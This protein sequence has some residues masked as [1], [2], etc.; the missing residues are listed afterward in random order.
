[1]NYE[2]KV[3]H[4]FMKSVVSFHNIDQTIDVM[5]CMN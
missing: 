1:M 4:N 5:A 3:G 2:I